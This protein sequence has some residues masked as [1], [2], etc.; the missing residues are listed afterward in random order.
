MNVKK[1]AGS[2]LVSMILAACGGGGGSAGTQAGGSGTGTGSSA[3]V[4]SA[5]ADFV[6]ELNKN[7]ILNNGGDSAQLT[8]IALDA[9]RNAL[10]GV[11]VQVALSPDGIFQKTSDVTDANGKFSGEIGIGGSKADRV[12]DATIKVG[13]VTKVAS[14]V[15][16]GSQLNITPVPATPTPGQTVVLNISALDSANSALVNLPLALTGPAGIPLVGKTDLSGNAI[17]SF[18]AP[19]NSGP[20]TVSAAGSGI[21]ASKIIEVI[22]AGA[23][24]KPQAIGAVSSASLSPVPTSIKP[25]SVGSTANRS[26][27]EAKFLAAG[28]VGIE[29]M[30][31]RFN[32]VA[33][34]LGGGEVISTGDAVVFSDNSGIA[35]ADYI[36]G[37]RSSPTNGVVIRA[38]YSPSDFTSTQCPA[39]VTATLTVAGDPLSISIGDNNE[40]EK[41]LGNIAYI[42]KFLI[43]VNDASGVAVP[44]A[45]VSVSTDITHYGKGSFDGV[46]PRGSTPPT[47]EDGS[48]ARITVV[49]ST[50]GTTSSVVVTTSTVAP[51]ATTIGGTTTLSNIWCINEDSDRNGSLDVASGEDLNGDGVLQPRKAEIIVSYVNGNRTDVNGQMLAQVSYSQ[52]MGSWLAYTLRATTSVA[53][54]EGDASKSY[55][56]DVLQADVANGSFL[57]PPFG[58]QSCSSRN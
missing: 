43:Q 7:T 14:I 21:S 12:I 42:K 34:A 53:G 15:V 37:T 16:S 26:R 45:I 24:G 13:G 6:F 57:T 27:L 54:S 25:N 38:C 2:V 8:V 32:I 3:E 1:M 55:V 19:L 46:Y 22:P 28:N 52:N 40:M 23:G 18:L 47:I 41:G 44:G 50:T 36:A 4:P 10:A 35:Q 31:V 5:V 30:R 49:N 56:A 17:V 58:V 29:N 33:P 51:M 48:L 39:S 11:G 9:K 20:F